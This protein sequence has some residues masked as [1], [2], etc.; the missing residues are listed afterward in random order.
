MDL[1]QTSDFINKTFWRNIYIPE[2]E[3]SDNKVYQSKLN[4]IVELF[5]KNNY[6]YVITDQT[7]DFE[8][9]FIR[10]LCNKKNIPP[11]QNLLMNFA[12]EG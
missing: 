5:E 10:Y 7:P 3:F 4:Q 11:T 6:T 12:G 2:S 1:M 9:S 8:Q